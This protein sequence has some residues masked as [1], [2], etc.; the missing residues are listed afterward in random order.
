M[1]V[2]VRVCAGTCLS[3]QQSVIVGKVCTICSLCVDCNIYYNTAVLFVLYI[4]YQL[5][6]WSWAWNTIHAWCHIMLCCNN[7]L[8]YNVEYIKTHAQCVEAFLVLKVCASYILLMIVGCWGVDVDKL[9]LLFIT[10]CF[11][12]FP[13][14]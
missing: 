8:T 2:I 3:L 4:I 14:R 12:D 10:I 1:Y 13:F 5:E 6:Y 7:I 9:S 11:K